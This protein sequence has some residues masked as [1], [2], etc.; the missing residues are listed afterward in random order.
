MNDP[1]CAS[2][3]WAQL[4]TVHSPAW[5]QLTDSVAW[6]LAQPGSITQ[7]PVAKSAD[8]IHLNVTELTDIS[9]PYALHTAQRFLHSAA[10]ISVLP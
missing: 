9:K 3:Q 10:A 2:R 6:C 5:F 4:P 8:I 7:S 1:Y